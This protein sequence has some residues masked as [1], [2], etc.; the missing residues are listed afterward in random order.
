MKSFKWILHSCDDAHIALDPCFI[1]KVD[2]KILENTQK[3]VF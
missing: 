1:C 3:C 2:F